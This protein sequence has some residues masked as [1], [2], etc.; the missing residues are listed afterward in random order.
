VN[1][2]E[3]ML[4]FSN[5]HKSGMSPRCDKFNLIANGSCLRVYKNYKFV[6]QLGAQHV[7]PGENIDLQT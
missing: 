6:P 4:L 1:S 7:V 5:P 3:V 2:S